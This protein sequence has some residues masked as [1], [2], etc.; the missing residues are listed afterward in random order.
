MN[1]HKSGKFQLYRYI[2]NRIQA[3]FDKIV[4]RPEVTVEI[5]FFPAKI[6]ILEENVETAKKEANA[7]EQRIQGIVHGIN[8]DLRT[9]IHIV[10]QVFVNVL[11]LLYNIHIYT[12]DYLRVGT[13]VTS[14]M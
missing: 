3:H 12:K 6:T 2:V 10:N 1:R 8:V 4:F 14:T 13:F 7:T 11:L 5:T 9:W